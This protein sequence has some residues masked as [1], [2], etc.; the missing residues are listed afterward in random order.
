VRPGVLNRDILRFAGRVARNLE[1]LQPSLLG[2]RIE[3]HTVLGVV[4]HVRVIEV[5]LV[6]VA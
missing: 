2:M 3:A 1:L 6:H 5:F 4:G